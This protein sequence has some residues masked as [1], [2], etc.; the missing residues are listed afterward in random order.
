M[1]LLKFTRCVPQLDG[2][3]LYSGLIRIGADINGKSR[4]DCFNICDH[5]VAFLLHPDNLAEEEIPRHH[6]LCRKING[7]FWPFF[8]KKADVYEDYLSKGGTV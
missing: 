3:T 7:D 8:A 2:K 4:K 1:V 6:G 5:L